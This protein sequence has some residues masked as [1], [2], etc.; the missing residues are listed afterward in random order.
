MGSRSALWLP[1]VL[2]LSACAGNPLRITDSDCPA[3][4]VV[5]N[6]G[7]FTLFRP[8]PSRTPEDVV[9]TATITGVRDNC[10]ET[11]RQIT[12]DIEFVIAARR[13]P[14][15]TQDSITVQYFATVIR[16]DRRLVR[17]A[18]YETQLS[19]GG[20]DRQIKEEK[21]RTVLLDTDRAN[22]STYEVLLGFQLS[23]DQVAY[24]V[25]R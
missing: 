14:A 11:I 7:S 12:S 6:T 22:I 1:A 25:L 10:R 9:M 16:D 3:V 17:K 4:A 24:N 23:D 15:A 8:G 13:G 20:A 5:K 2:L 19:F 21:V 18:T